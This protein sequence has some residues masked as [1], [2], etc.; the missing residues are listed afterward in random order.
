MK[1]AWLWAGCQGRRDAGRS[2]PHCIPTP[3]SAMQGEDGW[4]LRTGAPDGMEGASRLSLDVRATRGF[5][6]MSEES[7][8]GGGSLEWGKERGRADGQF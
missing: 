2:L 5:L 6:L 3:R 8:G 7:A 1:L 4:L